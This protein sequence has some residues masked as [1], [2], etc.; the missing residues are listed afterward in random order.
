MNPESTD[1]S[2]ALLREAAHRLADTTAPYRVLTR[3]TLAEL[4]GISHW[5][6]V[7]FDQALHWAVDHD[8]LRRLSDDMYEIGPGFSPGP[9]QAPGGG[10]RLVGGMAT[11]SSRSDGR[12]RRRLSTLLASAPRP[13]L[14]P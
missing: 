12:H 5:N 14:S 11:R 1:R 4:S 8:F 13:P 6:T 10:G 2:D 9:R 3:E 7:G